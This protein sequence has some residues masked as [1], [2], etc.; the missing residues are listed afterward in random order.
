MN[1]RSKTM[2]LVN[3]LEESARIAM[4]QL[5]E[6]KLRSLLTALGVIIG[7]WAVILIGVGINGLDTGFSKSLSM[8]GSDTFY[9]ERWPWK[10]VGDDWLKYY[11]RPRMETRYAEEL[12]EII[13]NT[14][15]SHLVVAVPTLNFKQS[16]SY[17]DQRINDIQITSTNSEFEYVNSADLNAGRFFTQPESSSGQ[18]VVILGH[19]VVKALFPNAETEIVGK[20][21]KI[22]RIQFRVIGT[23]AEQG[24]FLGM[25]SFD[26][27]AIIPLTAARKFFVARW[28]RNK[29]D[30]RIVKES[31]ADKDSARDEI[32]GAMRR[33]RSLLPGKENDF[34]VNASDSI[35]NQLGPVKTGIAVAGF[36]ITGLALFVGA[37]GITNPCVPKLK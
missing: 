29:T 27:Q 6:H 21:V 8:L 32:T 7:V 5:S 10:D 12:N 25:Q 13:A 30:I 4:Q 22:A 16:I 33:V 31:D 23:L 9:V 24:S 34:E 35:E 26:N 11:R 15:N 36:I 18:N 17:N 19:G 1:K 28:G 20:R 14:P 37:I 2:R 3:D